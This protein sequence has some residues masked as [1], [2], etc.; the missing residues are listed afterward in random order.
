MSNK[1]KLNIKTTPQIRSIYP[2]NHCFTMRNIASRGSG[3]TTFLI[4]FLWSLVYNKIIK[5]KDIYIFCS[6]FQDQY[7]WKDS[8]F[9]ERNIEHLTKEYAENKLLVFDDM[10]NLL[11]QKNPLIEDLFIKGRHNK[12]GIIQCEQY[13][14][15]TPLIKKANTDFIVLIAPFNESSAPYYHEKF[16]PSLSS[17]KIIELGN[18]CLDYQEEENNNEL[19]YLI[20]NKFGDVSIGYKYRVCPFENGNNFM[21]TLI[22]Y[23]SV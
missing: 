11:K 14:Q 1:L 9:Q 21:T 3:K 18:L 16:I 13:T 19:K 22:E 17:K 20:V 15:S 5:E 8:G 4:A 23:K 6:T 7:I 12:T 10:Q 2:T